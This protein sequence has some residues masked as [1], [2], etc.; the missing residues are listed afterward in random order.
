MD[1][2]QLEALR[3]SRVFLVSNVMPD[4][5]WDHLV[6]NGVFTDMMLEY[7]QCKKP[8]SEQVRTILSDLNRRHRGAYNAFLQCLDETGHEHCAE[9]IR[10]HEMRYRIEKG[11][12]PVMQETSSRSSSVQAPSGVFVG[13]TAQVVNTTHQPPPPPLPSS[14]PPSQP[15]DDDDDVEMRLLQDN[16]QSYSSEPP[17]I[18]LHGYSY[19]RRWNTDDVYTMESTPRGYVLVINNKEF[20]YMQARCGTDNDVRNVKMLFEGLGFGVSILHNLTAELMRTKLR[21]FAGS[22]PW[23]QVDSCVVVILT[24]GGNDQRM[25]GVDGKFDNDNF[26]TNRDLF[27]TFGSINCPILQGKP[28]LFLIQACRGTEEDGGC[29]SFHTK[30]GSVQVSEKDITGEQ[31]DAFGELERPD[32]RYLD[33]QSLPSFSDMIIAQSSV[34]GFVS[35]RNTEEGSYFINSVVEVF[36]KCAATCDIHDMLTK[37]NRVIAENFQTHDG[38]K[39]MPASTNQLLKKWFLNP[40][41]R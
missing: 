30:R 22:C 35:Y 41:F 21:E 23:N 2:F 18:A 4:S 40:K 24:H 1:E 3:R 20:H 12:P 37:V 31:G 7:I 13:Q 5:L 39:M 19:H 29:V 25:Y 14:Q 38:K 17:S 16:P 8:R 32:G 36:K 6:E 26:I 27:N 11:L 33:L 34:A 9:H 15:V 10:N 28:K